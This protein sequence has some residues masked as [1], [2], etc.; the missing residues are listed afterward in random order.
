[1][2]LFGDNIKKIET[3][4]NSE[5]HAFE[6]LLQHYYVDDQDEITNFL[7]DLGMD[8]IL[9][10]SEILIRYIEQARSHTEN[11]KKVEKKLSR[12]VKQSSDVRKYFE[13]GF[14]DEENLETFENWKKSIEK[15]ATRESRLFFLIDVLKLCIHHFGVYLIRNGE[16][17]NIREVLKIMDPKNNIYRES[18]NKMLIDEDIYELAEKFESVYKNDGIPQIVTEFVSD[19]E[20]EEENKEENEN[21]VST[22]E[23][24]DKDIDDI[25]N[26]LLH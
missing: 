4:A 18:Y 7:A 5:S 10:L 21:V 26:T 8:S 6:K 9:S 17:E 11:A 20:E 22:A 15:D 2:V 12:F 3:S 13:T 1:M 14:T 23:K 19:N 16:I 25:L 24:L